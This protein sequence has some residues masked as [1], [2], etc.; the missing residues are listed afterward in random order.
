MY[1]LRYHITSLVA[2]FLAL[3]VGLLLGGVVVE[4]GTLQG[5]KTTLV[6]SLK[7]SYEGL[8]AD[9]RLLKAENDAFASFSDQ[10]VPSVVSGTLEGR[11]IVVLTDPTSGDVVSQVTKAVREAGGRVAVIT[12]TAPGLG[13]SVPGRHRRPGGRDVGVHR[14]RR[15]VDYAGQRSFADSGARQGGRDPGRRPD[16]RHGGRRRGVDIRLGHEGR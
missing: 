2:I 9:Q 7:K 6:D 11:T 8:S 3:T 4:R 5:Q 13:L 12:F 15:G 14:A 1:N 10:A 16:R